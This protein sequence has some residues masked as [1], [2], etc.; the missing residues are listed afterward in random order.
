MLLMQIEQ[1][2]L[3]N[4]QTFKGL[5]HALSIMHLIYALLLFFLFDKSEAFDALSQL[6]HQ[7]MMPPHHGFLEGN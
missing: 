6:L 1:Q 3:L 2:P 5:A 7:D 4:K